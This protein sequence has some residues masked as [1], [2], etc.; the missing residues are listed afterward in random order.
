MLP[1]GLGIDFVRIERNRPG[2]KSSILGVL[3]FKRPGTSRFRRKVRVRD[4]VKVESVGITII[5]IIIAD[6]TYRT[7]V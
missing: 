6:H 4:R 7:L 1:P 2:E 3:R 5:V